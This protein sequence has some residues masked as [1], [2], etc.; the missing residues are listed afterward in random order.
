MTDDTEVRLNAVLDWLEQGRITTEQAAARIRAMPLKSPP[1]KTDFAERAED[2]NGDPE[3]PQ[4]GS[5]FAI[6]DA[7]ADGRIDQDQYAALA[8]AAAEAAKRD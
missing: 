6:S 1:D 7:F 8:Q 5:A 3:V 2:A 4:P